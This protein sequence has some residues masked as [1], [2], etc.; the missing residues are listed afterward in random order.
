LFIAGQ[1]VAPLTQMSWSELPK[2]R[3]GSS[4]CSPTSPP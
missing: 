3:A 2:L 4:R 1:G